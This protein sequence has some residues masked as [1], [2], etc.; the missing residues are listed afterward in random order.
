MAGRDKLDIALTGSSETN[1]LPHLVLDL[2]EWEGVYVVGDVHGCIDEL[3]ALL[4]RLDPSPDDLVLFVG[5]LIS[6]GPASGAVVDLVR[7]RAN[8]HSVLGNNEHKLLQDRTDAGLDGDARQFLETLPLIIAF[9]DGLVVH[10]GIDPRRTLVDQPP[11]TLLTMRSLPPGNGYRG[12]FWFERYEGPLRVF[13]GHTVV[14]E[15]VITPQVVGLDTGCVYGGALSAY[16]YRKDKIIS[17]SAARTYEPRTE[18]KIH[19]ST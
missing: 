2:D 9:G 1:D 4:D 11:D 12:P 6:K 15:P 7:S 8:F 5:D 13:F 14:D 10:G 16:D 19:S 3:R 18:S 17:V